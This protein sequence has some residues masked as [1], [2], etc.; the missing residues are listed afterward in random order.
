M[1]ASTA[2]A[3]AA[4]VSNAFPTTIDEL[5]ATNLFKDVKEMLLKQKHMTK[6][7]KNIILSQFDA[8]SNATLTDGVF[9]ASSRCYLLTQE[10]VRSMNNA[11]KNE[12][13]KVS[14]IAEHLSCWYTMW[15]MA[16]ASNDTKIVHIKKNV[17]QGARGKFALMADSLDPKIEAFLQEK[18][19]QEAKKEAAKLKR[20]EAKT[21]KS[22]RD[23][24]WTY[25][26]PRHFN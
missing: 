11:S 20:Y 17:N 8:D 23:Q 9:N 7:S 6:Q 21:S 1:A 19:A 10:I 26:L 14:F 5:V 25:A 12:K 4:A 18:V 15:K 2:A 13:D 22:R 24:E 3:V 16:T